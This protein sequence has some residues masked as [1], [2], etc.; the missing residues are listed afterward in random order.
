M[1]KLKRISFRGIKLPSLNSGMPVFSLGHST[2]LIY[3][4]LDAV[5]FTRYKVHRLYD[6]EH[7]QFAVSDRIYLLNGVEF[8]GDDDSIVVINWR[9]LIPEGDQVVITIDGDVVF[10]QW[11]HL[12]IKDTNTALKAFKKFV[13]V[14][15]RTIKE[16]Q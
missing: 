4:G 11:K 1:P 3:H 6:P 7:D 2:I 10:K 16:I 15:E 12:F 5:S 9:E 13:C 8:K 14:V